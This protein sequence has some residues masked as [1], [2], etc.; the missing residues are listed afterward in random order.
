MEH[1]WQQFAVVAGTHLLAL[2]SP[3][4]DFFLVMRSALRNGFRLAAGVCLGIA[5]A[6]GVYI[7][8]ALT[9]VTLI[10][11]SGLLFS[12]LQWA[13][14]LYLAWLGARLVWS[15]DRRQAWTTD[16]ATPE[17]ATSLAREFATGFLSGIL[18]PK[19]SHFYTSLF[20]LA[21]DPRTPRSTQLGYGLWMFVMVLAWDLAVAAG[22]GHPYIG[23][24]FARHIAKVERVTGVVLLGLAG[25]VLYSALRA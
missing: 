21:V 17:K 20:A 7:F 16:R 2:L 5:L 9:G 6:N 23:G 18:N 1:G 3:G 13:G 8:I 25:G 15:K 24:Q 11:E 10:H 14:C 22:I 12:A 4:P 19:N